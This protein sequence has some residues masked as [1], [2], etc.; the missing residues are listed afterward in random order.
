MLRGEEE[1]LE[2]VDVRGYTFPCIYFFRYLKGG[3][4]QIPDIY[5]VK[6]GN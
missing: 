4:D 1:N 2:K 5:D 6:Q 3:C